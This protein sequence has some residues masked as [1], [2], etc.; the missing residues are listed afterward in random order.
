MRGCRAFRNSRH[1]DRGTKK[2]EKNEDKRRKKKKE[3]KFPKKEEKMAGNVVS[4]VMCACGGVGG[5]KEFRI[6]LP[7]NCERRKKEEKRRKE[8]PGN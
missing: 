3:K 2:E 4:H 6:F 5:Q 8:F 1:V 7:E